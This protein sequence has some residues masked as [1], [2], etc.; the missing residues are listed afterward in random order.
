MPNAR[1][2]KHVADKLL[3]A[4][5]LAR[6]Y[7]E[8]DYD[9]SGRKLPLARKEERRAVSSTLDSAAFAAQQVAMPD[10]EDVEKVGDLIEDIIEELKK[11][12]VRRRET[13]KPSSSES[14]EE[15]VLDGVHN[16]LRELS[17]GAQ[18]TGSSRHGDQP[19]H[20]LRQ[21]TP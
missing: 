18:V 15:S 8:A 17:G 1:L 13:S 3:G 11:E 14:S 6:D 2:S 4:I 12:G 16:K 19:M 7:I 21:V 9:S 20:R 10:V 5:E